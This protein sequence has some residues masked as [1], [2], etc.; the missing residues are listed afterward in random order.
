[1]EWWLVLDGTDGEGEGSNRVKRV[2]D[3]VCGMEDGV[4]SRV[5]WGLG[6]WKMVWRLEKWD[7]F[8][9]LSSW[10]RSWG[11]YSGILPGFAR[12]LGCLAGMQ[13]WRV[14]WNGNAYVV[15]CIVYFFG[16]ACRIAR[17]RAW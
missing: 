17:L 11:W 14:N 1:M 4:F 6:E 12:L 3:G 13:W 8:G 7:R 5:A 16:H 15:G 10:T 9:L 2:V